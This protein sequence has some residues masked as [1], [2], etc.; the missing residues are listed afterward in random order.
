MS[1][2]RRFTISRQLSPDAPIFIASDFHQ[3]RLDNVLP[4][5]QQFIDIP[6]RNASTLDLCY[7][8]IPNAYTSKTCHQLGSSDHVNI[9]LVHVPTYK[10]KLKKASPFLSNV[11]TGQMTQR[12]VCGLV[13]MHRLGC[14]IQ[15]DGHA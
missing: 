14:S 3:C 7:G 12:N 4:D 1:L 8:N 15:L 11:M 2:L 6:T 10:Q 5:L 9:H 13:R